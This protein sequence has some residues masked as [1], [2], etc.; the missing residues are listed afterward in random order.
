MT[1]PEYGNASI[2]SGP[3]DFP[4]VTPDSMIRAAV[5]WAM[6]MPS[7]MKTMTFLAG[8]SWA[9]RRQRA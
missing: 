6:P 8:R 9:S 5:R 4:W 7:P 1:S 2:A 3:R